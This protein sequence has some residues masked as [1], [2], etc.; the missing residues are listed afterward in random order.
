M[1]TEELTAGRLRVYPPGT[2]P[3][4]ALSS[5][6][7]IAHI[8]K[9]F[10]FEQFQPVTAEGDKGPPG[11][12][13]GRGR[14][15]AADPAATATIESL[16]IGSDQID[17]LT[18]TAD[19]HQFSDAILAELGRVFAEVVPER[20]PWLDG[21]RI[22]FL[23]TVWVGQLDLSPEDLID[24]RARSVLFPALTA[25]KG[26][27]SGRVQAKGITLKL[28]APTPRPDLLEL[29][30]QFSDDEFK[31]EPRAGRL[32]SERAWFS[33]SPLRSDDHL[34]LLEEVEATYRG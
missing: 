13:F 21:F 26:E 19:G 27:G 5:K 14:A 1:K 32:A 28:T 23:Q 3:L 17:L 7:A 15:P 8:G 12:L 20:G 33:T 10:G 9:T 11:L 34:R 2:I 4:W 31:L 29:G 6:R 16:R 24:P 30:L 22:E 18:R 25:S